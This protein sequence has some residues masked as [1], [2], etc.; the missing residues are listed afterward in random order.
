MWDCLWIVP[1][2]WTGGAQPELFDDAALAC[3]VGRITYAGPANAL[4][5]APARLAREEVTAV[6]R[7][8]EAQVIAARCGWH[9]HQR[10]DHVPRSPRKRRLPEQRLIQRRAEA[11]LIALRVHLGAAELLRRNMAS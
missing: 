5:D 11:E 2:L 3:Q 10:A 4:P 7:Q 8:P 1:R 6:K 9:G